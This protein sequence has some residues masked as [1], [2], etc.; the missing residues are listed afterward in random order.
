V[1][2]V[3]W[4]WPRLKPTT[5]LRP[6]G[7]GRQP[8]RS[9][10]ASGS[11]PAGP[12]VLVLAEDPTVGLVLKEVLTR[13]GHD[14]H[15]TATAVEA[16]GVLAAG[17]VDAVVSDTATA[18]TAGTQLVEL[19]RSDRA[20]M[21]VLFLIADP[22]PPAA[23]GS[24]ASSAAGSTGDWPG[25]DTVDG[26]A[27]ELTATVEAGRRLRSLL[28]FAADR[29]RRPAARHRSR[30]PSDPGPSITTDPPGEPP[31]TGPSR[32]RETAAVGAFSGVGG[33]GAHPAAGVAAPGGL[34]T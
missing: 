26:R 4:P 19:I 2:Q 24:S 13:D 16:F 20:G 17:P 18:Q 9:C 23:S 10:P 25:V 22:I 5:V 31:V 30:L 1:E 6:S 7:E 12:R 15:L 11:T 33:C 21:P 28:E 34:F 32:C 3:S 27:G 29:D 8:R 14:V